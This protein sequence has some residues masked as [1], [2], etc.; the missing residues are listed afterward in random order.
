VPA[1][2][3]VALVGDRQVRV[4][5]RAGRLS[6]A[7][8]SPVSASSTARFTASPTRMSAGTRSPASQHDRVA[9]DELAR[10]HLRL[11][12]ARSACQRRPSPGRLESALGTIPQ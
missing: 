3:H 7:S 5:E 6:T 9:G 12:A 11:D 4:G 10:R 2:G 1:E 8:D